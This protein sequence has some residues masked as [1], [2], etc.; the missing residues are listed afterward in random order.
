M[1]HSSYSPLFL[2]SNQVEKVESHLESIE[3][4]DKIYKNIIIFLLFI[5]IILF[6]VIVIL[7]IS[8]RYKELLLETHNIY[9]EKHNA[10]I[11]IMI[12]FLKS[13]KIPLI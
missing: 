4:K 3:R 8:L 9:T 11:D 2:D 6:C 13:S 7:Y 10:N 1:S 5:I 12:E